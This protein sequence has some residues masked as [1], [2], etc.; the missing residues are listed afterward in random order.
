[1]L[2]VKAPHQGQDHTIQ[3]DRRAQVRIRRSCSASVT[4]MLVMGQATLA[5]GFRQRERRN[6]GQRI[7]C[8]SRV[9]VKCSRSQ[10]DAC[11]HEVKMRPFAIAGEAMMRMSS[12]FFASMS[13]FRATR[14]TSVS[15]FRWPD[16]SCVTQI[17]VRRYRYHQAS[18][19]TRSPV[20]ASMQVTIPISVAMKIN[21]SCCTIEDVYGAPV[22]TCHSSFDF[23][24]VSTLT[25][26]HGPVWSA[27]VSAAHIQ[28]A[29]VIHG[30]WY[31]ETRRL[32]VPPQRLAGGWIEAS[33]LSLELT[34]T[35]APCAVS[36]TRG[37]LKHVCGREVYCRFGQEAHGKH[38]VSTDGGTSVSTS[39]P[40]L[41]TKSPHSFPF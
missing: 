18:R 13:G 20:F 23:R 4:V 8:R 3:V 26:F 14:R 36:T 40:V 33:M 1:M 21:P 27:S 35:S 2:T 37:V 16:R 5:R 22:S 30:H 15:P 19:H 28:G 24:H 34:I 32:H 41:E 10:R 29:I 11:R 12:L 17:W 6:T 39:M 7:A 38:P 25:K 9:S 31:R